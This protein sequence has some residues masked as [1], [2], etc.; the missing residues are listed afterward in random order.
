MTFEV[1]T[2]F[3]NM[4]QAMLTES[5]LKK[6]VDKGL[7]Q[8]KI[9]DLRNWTTDERKTIDDRPFGGGPGMLLM[10]EPIYKCMLSLKLYP[11]R[12]ADTKV[13]L[14]SAG[15]K[16]WNQSEAQSYSESVSRLVIIC[17]HYE[18][19]DH[20]V[21]EHLVDQEVSVGNYVLTGGELA[22]GIIIDSTARLING[23]LGNQ[24]SLSEESHSGIQKE[25]P[26][27]TRPAEFATLDGQTWSV[28]GV[29]TS[30]NHALI[31]EWKK[32]NSL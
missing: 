16:P 22:A 24:D 3:P 6:A 25:Y 28:P 26:Q 7:I 13:I 20:R 2:A 14:T 27:Y 15:G 18:G 12:P 32:Q 11:S 8:V 17:G 21:V 23:V 10:L 31:E 19:V 30:G 5:I 1:I 4:I 29:L 9:H